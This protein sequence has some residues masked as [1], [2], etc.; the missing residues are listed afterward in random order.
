MGLLQSSALP[1]GYPAIIR[2]ATK[3]HARLYRKTLFASFRAAEQVSHGI[4]VINVEFYRSCG[5]GVC[6]SPFLNTDRRSLAD[7]PLLQGLTS[8][9]CDSLEILLLGSLEGLHHVEWGHRFAILTIKQGARSGV[10]RLSLGN[11]ET[12]LLL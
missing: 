2:K 12:P 11:K 4:P 6:R 9:S 10:L 1:L 7:V 8:D 3:R 5:G